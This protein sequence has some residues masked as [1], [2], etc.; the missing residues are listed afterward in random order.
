[1]NRRQARQLKKALLLNKITQQRSELAGN[2]QA[3]L[4]QTATFDNGCLV[5]MKYPKLTAA[6]A[7]VLA[8]YALRRPRKLLLWSRRAL[9]IWSTLSFVRNNLNVNLNANK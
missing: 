5:L 9:G 4:E 6:G 1:M 7:G 3:F 8:V 2:R